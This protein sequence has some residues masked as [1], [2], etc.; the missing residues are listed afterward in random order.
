VGRYHHGHVLAPIEIIDHHGDSDPR[1]IFE[2]VLSLTKLNWNSAGYAETMPITLRFSRLVGDVL[3][4]VPPHGVPHARY[5][6]Y[7]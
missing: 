5:A 2:E 6:F 7:M 3:R 1:R 4:E